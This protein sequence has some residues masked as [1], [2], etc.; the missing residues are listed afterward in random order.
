VECKAFLRIDYC[1]DY[2]KQTGKLQAWLTRS[3]SGCL[4]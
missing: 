2:G 3:K 4:P 1:I